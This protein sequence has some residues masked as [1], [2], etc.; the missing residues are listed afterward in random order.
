MSLALVVVLGGA[1]ILAQSP[2]LMMLKP[3]IVH[4]AIGVILLRPG[5][6]L[7][8]LPPIAREHLSAGV[9]VAA[10]YGWAALLFALA[11]ANFVVA[12]NYDIVTW[13]WFVG[14]GLF[15][16]KVIAFLAQYVVFGCFLPAGRSRGLLTMMVRALTE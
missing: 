3:S 14:F 11:I 1:T 4:L 7:R 10:G 9:V 5:W 13:G 12:T 6:M 16:A 15:G 2:R 8:Y